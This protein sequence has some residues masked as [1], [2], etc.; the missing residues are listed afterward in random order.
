MKHVFIILFLIY[1]S[2]AWSQLASNYG[3]RVY[4]GSV[5]K[6]D[7]IA[8]MSLG[9]YKF[10]KKRTWKDRRTYVKYTKLVKK[11]KK[12]Y[13]YAALAGQKLEAYAAEIDQISSERKT[14][15]YYK[16]VEEELKEEYEGQLRKLTVSE[17]RILIKLIDRETGNTSY[18]LVQ[19]LRGNLSA[20]L[21]QGLAR[22]FGQDLKAPYDP[23]GED[24]EFEFI[25]RQIEAGVI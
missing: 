2:T 11:V 25:V 22:V 4:P 12:V 24:K 23:D 20:F 13:P 14:K 21:W 5:Y 16:Q 10:V 7:T 8:V 9:E 3:N 6:G 15:K 19:D 1:S 17:G 18:E